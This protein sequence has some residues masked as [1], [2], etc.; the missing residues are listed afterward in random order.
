MLLHVILSHI[1]IAVGTDCVDT[2]T[3]TIMKSIVHNK[4]N[5][6]GSDEINRFRMAV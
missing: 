1:T 3:G 6:L 4:V 5:V 2:I